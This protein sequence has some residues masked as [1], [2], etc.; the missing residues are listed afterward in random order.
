MHVL[1]F[2]QWWCAKGSVFFLS[3]PDEAPPSRLR[4]CGQKEEVKLK[5]RSFV[6]FAE[7]G[8]LVCRS[9]QTKEKLE[10]KGVQ[11]VETVA[12]E[13]CSGWL[14]SERTKAS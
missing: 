5:G 11:F 4:G 3:I 14:R 7:R 10:R 1:L 8:V 2:V 12:L 6:G 9:E 13:A